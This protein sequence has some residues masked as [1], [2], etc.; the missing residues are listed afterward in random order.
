MNFEFVYH[1]IKKTPKSS[2]KKKI[3]ED[4]FIFNFSVIFYIS[5]KSYTT[6]YHLL[7]K[8]LDLIGQTSLILSEIPRGYLFPHLRF[9]TFSDFQCRDL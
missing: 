3:D 2:Q 4:D 9:S 7:P 6:V 1:G 8:S 5:G